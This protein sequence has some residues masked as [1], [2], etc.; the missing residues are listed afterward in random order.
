MYWRFL[1]LIY[2]YI[3]IKPDLQLHSC[4][5]LWNFNL[6]FPIIKRIVKD[7]STLPFDYDCVKCK[8]ESIRVLSR[9]YIIIV[10]FVSTYEKKCKVSFS[11]FIEFI[12][13]YL[14]WQSYYITS[15]EYG[16]SVSNVQ[17]EDENSL[18]LY[19]IVD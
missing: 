19:S 4:K 14:I 1:D 18:N 8:N 11:S 13:C 3:Y 10:L 17:F 5:W 6:P 15:M 16:E 2:F 7:N 12:L 9:V